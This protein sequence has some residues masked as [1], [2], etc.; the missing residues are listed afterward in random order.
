M[1]LLL[2]GPDGGGKS[3]LAATIAHFA[4][5]SGIT[6]AIRHTGAPDP[7][8]RCPFSE[9][10]ARL[11]NDDLAKAVHSIS[12]LLILDRHHTGE[13][14]YG[15]M[16][17]GRSR[18]TDNG[19]Y[20]IE[21]AIEALACVKL[22]VLP[23]V[24][25]ILKRLK[26]RKPADLS[27]F[28]KEFLDVERLESTW[29]WYA[30][31]G[32]SNGYDLISDG[33][34]DLPGLINLLRFKTHTAAFTRQYSGGTYIGCLAPQVLACG[35]IRGAGRF[36]RKDLTRPFT[37]TTSGG[38]S[39][40]LLTTLRESE[41]RR[42]VGVVN[43][44]DPAVR[45]RQLYVALSWPKVVALGENASATLRAEGINHVKI[46]HPAWASRFRHNDREWYAARLADAVKTGRRR[47][48]D[49]LER[50]RQ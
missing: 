45:I 32:P 27:E 28:D 3:T 24:D 48:D 46:P 9:Y 12:E 14:V 47:D 13:Q 36:A 15:P 16:F 6:T 29:S 37:P 17:R 5:A 38:S 35:D 25:L 7:P 40:Y 21:L 4:E 49:V 39:N 11:D 44:N 33:T 19:M 10:E 20:H 42:R 26:E 2:E 23:P 41:F 34:A 30:S 22:L 18:L 1:L 8:G 43:V 50:Q 31:Y